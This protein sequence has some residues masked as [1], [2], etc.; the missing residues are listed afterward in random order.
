MVARLTKPNTSLGVFPVANGIS[1]M[2]PNGLFRRLD[3]GECIAGLARQF[4]A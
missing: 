1:Y 3:T 4:R 2:S